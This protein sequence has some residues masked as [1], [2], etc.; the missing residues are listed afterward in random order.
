[1]LMEYTNSQESLAHLQAHVNESK[2][3]LHLLLTLVKVLR[4]RRISRRLVP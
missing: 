2:R 3:I 4:L 1:M